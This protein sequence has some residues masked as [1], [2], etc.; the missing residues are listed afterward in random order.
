MAEAIIRSIIN[1]KIASPDAIIASDIDPARR[2]Y[3]QGEYGICVTED[4]QRALNSSEIIILSIKPQ[5]L[6][7]VTKQLSGQIEPQQLVI[8]IIAGATISSLSKHLNHNAI[9]RIMPN[10][11]AQIGEGISVWTATGNV[12]DSQKKIVAS[13]LNALG[14]EIY[15]DDEK[16][17]DMATAVSGSG[18]AYIYLIIESLIEAAVHIG[19]PREISEK[20]VLQTVLGSTR[21]LQK[22]GKHP[23]EL[24]NMVTSPGGTTAEGLFEL[25]DGGLRSL[26]MRAIIAS[27]EKA[28]MLGKQ[29]E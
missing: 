18:P 3:L 2:T 22:S 29:T 7:E 12:Q 9:V 13:I 26:L 28:K 17:I 14:K 8:S 6:G 27:Y 1:K 4:N 25:E 19:I 10:M 11:P 16:Y 5:V 23:A 20:L 15:F 24:K 21:V